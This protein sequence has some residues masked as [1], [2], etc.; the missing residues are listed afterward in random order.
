MNQYLWNLSPSSTCFLL[1]WYLQSYFCFVL[2]GS[3]VHTRWRL[4]AWQPVNWTMEQVLPSCLGWHL[5]L[6]DRMLGN[7]WYDSLVAKWV[8]VWRV[9]WE[10]EK[11]KERGGRAFGGWENQVLTRKCV[12]YRTRTKVIR[13]R[14][15]S[16]LGDCYFCTVVM[17]Q[18]WGASFL[19]VLCWIRTGLFSLDTRLHFG[20]WSSYTSDV[21]DMLW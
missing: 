9:V 21:S 14:I 2:S 7:T 16:T 17:W 20:I 3:I 8:V 11:E 10:T 15:T 13:K 12:E 18:A 6:V 5:P 4:V 1:L 19:I